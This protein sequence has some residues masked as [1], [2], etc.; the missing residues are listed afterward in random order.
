MLNKK[1]IQLKKVTQLTPPLILCY[2]QTIKS[3][4]SGEIFY[5][6]VQI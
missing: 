2:R 6:T 4:K 3:L 1:I 5:L